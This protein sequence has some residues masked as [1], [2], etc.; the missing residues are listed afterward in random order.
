VVAK[1]EWHAGEL[2]P[3]VGF[4]VTNLNQ[5]SKNVVNLRANKPIDAKKLPDTQHPR[6]KA[7]RRSRNVGKIIGSLT[8]Q[9][10]AINMGCDSSLDRFL[11][12]PKWEM[13]V[14]ACVRI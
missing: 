3:R 9:R 8:L 5:H 14:K 2:F 6:R 1:I 7:E 13:S 10:C 4:I 12:Q 11:A